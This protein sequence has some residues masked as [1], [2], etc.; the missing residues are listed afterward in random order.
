MVSSAAL[1]VDAGDEAEE[2]DSRSG[3]GDGWAGVNGFLLGKG[4]GRNVTTMA[5]TIWY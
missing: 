5:I 2:G 1:V 4:L 3:D